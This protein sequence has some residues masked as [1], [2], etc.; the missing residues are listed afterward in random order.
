M[1]G[2]ARR[3]RPPASLIQAVR[4]RLR[5][6]RITVGAV[7]LVRVAVSVRGGRAPEREPSLTSLS[8][9]TAR[10]GAAQERISG[11]P[12]GPG[13]DL[14]APPPRRGLK[15]IAQRPGRGAGAGERGVGSQLGGAQAALSTLGRALARRPPQKKQNTDTHL[16]RLARTGGGGGRGGSWAG[17]DR[18]GPAGMQGNAGQ[19]GRGVR[20]GRRWGLWDNTGVF[21]APRP[22]RP[23]LS[24]SLY[25]LRGRRAARLAAAL[26]RPATLA[27]LRL[28]SHLRP[29]LLGR[30]QP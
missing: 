9:H 1:Q 15:V 21:F 25:S 11:R 4:P 28:R 8:V 26:A 17:P 7:G 3:G 13:G 5:A 20:P 22:P 14:P 6:P 24:L 23:R 2:P 29:L 30:Q 27:P 10:R 19:R 12:R 18:S 16:C